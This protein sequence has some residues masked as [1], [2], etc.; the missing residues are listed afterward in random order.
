MAPFDQRDFR[1]ERY[2]NNRL[3]RDFGGHTRHPSAQVVSTVFKELVH[4][5]LEKIKTEP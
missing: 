4:Q 5:I 1:L 3:R 2:N